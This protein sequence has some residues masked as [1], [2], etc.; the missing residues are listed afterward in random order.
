MPRS[1]LVRCNGLP[2]VSSDAFPAPANQT[3]EV[4]ADLHL[5]SNLVE[6]FNTCLRKLRSKPQSRQHHERY[7]SNIVS[8]LLSSE[9][10]PLSYSLPLH[11]YFPH[12]ETKNLFA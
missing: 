3:H 4:E 1:S 5:H 10:F 8:I 2:T 7:V 12:T 6:L 9:G 11:F